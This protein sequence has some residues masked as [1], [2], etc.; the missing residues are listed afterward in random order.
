MTDTGPRFNDRHSSF[1]THIANQ[2]AAP[3]GNNQV[4]PSFGMQQRRRSLPARRKQLH[5]VRVGPELL[6]HLLNELHDSPVGS[7]RITPSFQDSGVPTF[8]AQRKHIE[9]HIRTGFINHPNYAE[10]HTHFF[11]S[12]PARHRITLQDTP[13][14]GRKHS[15]LTHVGR[16]PRQPFLCQLQTVILRIGNFHPQQVLPIGLQQT[17]CF[18]LYPVGHRTQ[19]CI[20]R[21]HIPHCQFTGCCPNGLKYFI[22]I[23]FHHFQITVYRKNTISGRHSK[24]SKGNNRPCQRN[25]CPKACLFPKVCYL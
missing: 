5:H 13:Q 10:R 15:H 9:T 25:I 3:T 16:N 18:L 23:H 19:K 4:H 21:F 22:Q 11:Q 24:L 6:Q 1:L 20:H 8:Q 17:F 2:T 14:R 7:I 12:Q